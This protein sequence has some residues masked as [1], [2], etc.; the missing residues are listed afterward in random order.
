V[1]PYEDLIE[2]IYS[3]AS[4]P[5]EWRAIMQRISTVANARECAMQGATLAQG[6]WTPKFIMGYEIG[7]SDAMKHADLIAEITDPRLTAAIHVPIDNTYEERNFIT[8]SEM[9]V[10]PY[11]RELW[12]PMEMKYMSGVPALKVQTP[13]GLFFGGF[14][15]QFTP[16]QGPIHGDSMR[17]WDTLRPH[18]TRAMRLAWRLRTITDQGW[19]KLTGSAARFT[20]DRLG[21]VTTRNELGEQLLA[22]N[23]AGIDRDR[24]LSFR[25]PHLQLKVNQCLSGELL[26]ARTTALNGEVTEFDRVWKFYLM[27]LQSDVALSTEPGGIPPFVNL[28]LEEHAK[29]RYKKPIL[30]PAESRIAA[31]LAEGESL[32]HIAASLGIS[33]ETARSQCKSAMG[34]FDVHSQAALVARWLTLEAPG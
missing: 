21:R 16:R 18:L 22:R 28:F 10:H 2:D 13:A 3:A 23:I 17:A 24:R 14:A 11:Y 15:L 32:R 20:I 29:L 30:S 34:K 19:F 1:H 4:N 7:P 27:P 26:G 12:E 9:R 31:R 6:K 5:A 25:N 33:Y 8:E